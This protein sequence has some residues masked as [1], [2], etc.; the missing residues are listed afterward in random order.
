[1][2]PAFD[3]EYTMDGWEEEGVDEE[4][5]IEEEIEDWLECL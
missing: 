2:W 1:M 4:T 3:Y 5:E